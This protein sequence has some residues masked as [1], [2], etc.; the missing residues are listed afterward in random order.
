MFFDIL[1]VVRYDTA[2]FFC[3][4]GSVC[5]RAD[6]CQSGVL[7]HKNMSETGDCNR[8]KVGGIKRIYE[9]VTY[10]YRTVLVWV[11][12]RNMFHDYSDRTGY[13]LSTDHTADR[14]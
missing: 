12:V 11:F 9:K 5:K 2:G 7:Q 14:G 13:G 1:P 6:G 3:T 8:G 10:I 4:K